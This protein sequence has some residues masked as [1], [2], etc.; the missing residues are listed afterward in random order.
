MEF[1]LCYDTNRILKI[2]IYI[3]KVKQEAENKAD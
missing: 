3:I 2:P 1:S